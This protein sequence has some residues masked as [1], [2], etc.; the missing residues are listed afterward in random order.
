MI[1]KIVGM[2]CCLLCAFPLFI[3]GKY[4]KD[5]MTPINFWAGDTSLKDKIKD[6]K[7]Y[8]AEMAG[9]YCN[10]AL[11]FVITGLIFLIWE[12]AGCVIVLLDSTI[13]IYFVWKKYKAILA[14]YS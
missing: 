2:I 3:I 11:A 14:K 9:L 7:N 12:I 13:G 10:C 1:A 5:S 4:N 6:L 8:N